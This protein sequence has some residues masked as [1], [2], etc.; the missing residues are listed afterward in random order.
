MTD[1]MRFPLFF[2]K[3]MS[4]ISHR[5][6]MFQLFDGD[7]IF[8]GHGEKD[9]WAAIIASPD[10]RAFDNTC[11]CALATDKHYLELM[12]RL[13]LDGGVDRDYMY[14]LIYEVYNM[15]G[16]VPNLNFCRAF[17]DNLRYHMTNFGY[18]WPTICLTARVL[19]HLYYGFVAEN[20][21]NVDTNGTALGALI[22]MHAVCEVLYGHGD[23]ERAGYGKN[24]KGVI[25]TVRAGC[26]ARGIT[27]PVAIL[28]QGINYETKRE[29]SLNR[30]KTVHN[31]ILKHMPWAP[32]VYAYDKPVVDLPVWQP[33]FQYV[34]GRVGVAV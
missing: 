34:F 8:F 15:A 25:E 32:V 6:D 23:V 24:N 21:Y 12:Q 18:N 30:V 11:L 28:S 13:V 10:F 7:W 9:I 33:H 29:F 4:G 20:Y 5:R 27:L 2:N 3:V 31:Y 22:K 19:M 16:L 26:R 17:C 1:T 14:E